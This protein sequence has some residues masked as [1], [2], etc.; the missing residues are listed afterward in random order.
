[1]EV[2]LT[3][4]IKRVTRAAVIAAVGLALPLAASSTRHQS[5]A[6]RVDSL[7]SSLDALESKVVSTLMFGGSSP[8][9]FSGEARLKMQ[10]HNLGY[11]APGYMQADRTYLQSGWEGNENLFRLGMVARP[12]R[13]TVLWAKIGF[14]HTLTGNYSLSQDADGFSTYQYRHDKARNSIAIHEDMSA[15]IAVRTT[16]ASFWVKLGN[17]MWTEASPLTVWKA[18]PRT[19]AW[20]YLPFEVEQPIA[21]YYEYNIAKGEKSGRA[22][23]NKRPFNGINVESINLPAD[24]YA[25]FIYG[26]FERFDNF[27]REYIDFAGDLGYA[28]GEGSK[29]GFPEK[30]QGIGDSYRHVIHGRAAKS[31]LFGDM[32]LGLNYVGINY[33]DDVLFAHK[34]DGHDSYLLLREFGGYDS[35]F[36]KEPKTLSLDLRGALSETFSIHADV[37]LNWTDTTWWVDPDKTNSYVNRISNPGWYTEKG[38]SGSDIVFA[39]YTKLSYNG[40]LPIE[41]DLAFIGKGFYSP[42]SF[43]TPIDAFYAYGSNMVGAGKFIA[44]GEGSPYTQNMAG[45]NLTFSP[46]VPGYG[47]FKLKYGQHFNIED[48]QDLLFFPYRLNGS[49]MFTLFHSSF[50]RWGNALVDNSVK[51]SG[52][53]KGRLG[54]ESFVHRSSWFANP[55]VNT[56]SVA[57]PGAG[58][59]R[60]DYMS[61]FE[62]F[63]PYSSAEEA[64]NNF[65]VKRTANA[66][67]TTQS[68][69][70]NQ[71]F[72]GFR[73]FNDDGTIDVDSSKSTNTSWVPESKKY[74]F[75]LELDAAYDIG[76]FVGYRRDLF[77]G[78]YIGING[79]SGSVKPLAFDADTDAKG[80]HL[81]SM[82][83]R[84]EPAIALH[85]NF[86][87]LGLFGYENWRSQKSWMLANYVEGNPNYGR[88]MNPVTTGAGSVRQNS[89]VKVDINHRDFAYGIGFDWD[90]LERVGLH[91]RVKWMT[92]EDRGLN[93]YYKEV[94]KKRKDLNAARSAEQQVQYVEFTDEDRNDWATPVFSLEIKMWF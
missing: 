90:M 21:R 20:E 3:I 25:N 86:Y 35:V 52:T 27:E 33:R 85:K 41:A 22:A 44:R 26:T 9:S 59:L 7:E 36:Y 73:Y 53:Y 40:V 57:G 29:D 38:S 45:A 55:S 83:L 6:E 92:H 82:Y 89:F 10:Y 91:G 66:F 58:G 19:F 93:E 12:G 54:D 49:D 47:H 79:V 28:D 31:K 68:N 14:Q 34:G 37:A 64:Y 11:D 81:W 75:N 74:S 56:Q 48:G 8:V 43:A 2:R 61:M 88:Y 1:M 67:N 39:A 84:L 13:N 72:D 60:S 5:L 62:G 16:P 78:G 70:M 23:W 69:I 30:N 80:V 51:G 77:V 76:P 24:L 50:N 42:F 18:Q 87:L 71:S 4:F 17:T 94:E 15:G 65:R 46:K 32:T 63:V